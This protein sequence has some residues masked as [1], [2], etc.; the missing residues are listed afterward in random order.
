M[1]HAYDLGFL[2]HGDYAFLSVKLFDSLVLF[3]DHEWRQVG[4][5]NIMFAL[6]EMIMVYGHV[7]LDRIDLT[8]M[9]RM[10]FVNVRF[11]FFLCPVIRYYPPNAFVLI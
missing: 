10:L 4:Q 5:H 6:I 3:G 9:K 8:Y 1:L 2:D 11:M 7:T